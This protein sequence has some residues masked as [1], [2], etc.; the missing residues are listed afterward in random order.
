MDIRS[1]LKKINLLPYRLGFQAS[2]LFLNFPPYRRWITNQFHKLVYGSRLLEITWLNTKWMGIPLLK[3]PIDLWAYQELIYELKPDVLVECGSYLGGSAYYFAS[4]FELLGEGRV[5]SIDIQDEVQRANHAR[6]TYLIGSS[7]E[8]SIVKIVKDHIAKDEIVMVVLDSAHEK[9]HVL[10]E[11]RIYSQFVS[12][13]SY[14]VVEDTN[15]NG[16]PVWPGFGAGPREA[17]TAFLAENETFEVDRSWEKFYV[18]F[19]SGG[20]LKRV[21]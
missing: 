19:N 21:K 6:L 11:L 8:P 20:F 4:I 10:E 12:L 9:A 18:S 1:W 17:V 5:I 16:H 14:L 13:G 15:L 3:Y 2:G 7:T